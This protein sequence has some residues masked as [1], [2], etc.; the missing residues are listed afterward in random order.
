M[1]RSLV[2]ETT[3][4][5]VVEML[6]FKGAPVVEVEAYDLAARVRRAGDAKEEKKKNAGPL[7]SVAKSSHFFFFCKVGQYNSDSEQGRRHSRVT[8]SVAH[9][10]S[11]PHFRVLI[12]KRRKRG[13]VASSS[14]LNLKACR[15]Q[16]SCSGPEDLFSEHGRHVFLC[17]ML[18]PPPSCSQYCPLECETNCG[19]GMCGKVKRGIP[20]FLRN[21]APKTS[22]GGSDPGG[23]LCLRIKFTLT[24]FFPSPGTFARNVGHFGLPQ[25]ATQHTHKHHMFKFNFSVKSQY[26]PPSSHL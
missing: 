3:A 13:L 14:T 24:F 20:P 1:T 4:E 22:K 8:C 10:S 18:N 15:G 11:L 26:N 25:T 12:S 19:D 5:E 23:C 6:D 2:E 21:S 9:S 7:C 16:G 17:C